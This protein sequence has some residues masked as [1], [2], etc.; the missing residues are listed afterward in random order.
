MNQR[1]KS[2]E[3][4][5]NAINGDTRSTTGTHAQRGTNQRGHT[6]NGNQRE[7]QSTGT[8]INGDTRSAINGDT[9]SVLSVTPATTLFGP[10]DEMPVFQQNPKHKSVCPTELHHRITPN[11]T[12]ACVP[13]NSTEFHRILSTEFLPP[14]SYHRIPIKFMIQ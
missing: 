4:A 10:V 7:R 6:L 5:I 8:A 9:R 14:N 2:T 11:Y 13:P 1:N 3:R 12:K